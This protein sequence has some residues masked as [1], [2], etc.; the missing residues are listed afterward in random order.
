MALWYSPVMRTVRL[1]IAT[2][3]LVP[4][5]AFAD[6]DPGAPVPP[7]VAPHVIAPQPGFATTAFGLPSPSVGAAAFG[8]ASSRAANS[9]GG[10]GMVFGSPIDRL[11]LFGVGERRLDGRSAPSAMATFRFAGGAADGWALAGMARYKAEG[12]AEVEG[13][14]ELGLLGS[15]AS[16]RSYGDVNLVVGRGFDESETD[17]ELKL[18]VGYEPL[19]WL[20]TGVDGRARFRMGGG[21]KLPGDRSWDVVGGPQVLVG[22]AR[23]YGAVTVGPTTVGVASGV[24]WS[25]TLQVGGIA[26]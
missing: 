18:R 3:L 25:A 5:L 17:G 9:Y 24:G 15:F 21:A 23:F 11:T 20:R 2:T 22:G 14:V 7:P 19:S 10:G 12:F 6:S 8:S 16:R 13:E 4:S 1:V 26:W